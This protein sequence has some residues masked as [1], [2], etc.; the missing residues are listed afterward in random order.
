MK[1]YVS[2][3]LLDSAA[4]WLSKPFVDANFNMQQHLTGQSE[5]Q[6]RWK[7]CVDAT[8]GALG[9]ALGQKYVDEAFGADGKQ[10]M[11]KMVALEVSLDQDIRALP[12]MTDDTKETGQ[13]EVG[14]DPQ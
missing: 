11:L 4:P 9:E 10:R 5:I 13:G 2:W 14:G 8:D 3:H 1:T 7:R 12:W 6:A